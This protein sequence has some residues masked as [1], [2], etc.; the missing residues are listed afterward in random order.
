M[1][2]ALTMAGFQ[3]TLIGRIWVTPEGMKLFVGFQSAVIDPKQPVAI[4]EVLLI[5]NRNVVMLASST[6]YVTRYY[7][8]SGR[9]ATWRRSKQPCRLFE[10]LGVKFPHYPFGRHARM[11]VTTSNTRLRLSFTAIIYETR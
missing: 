7:T 6:H 1:S 5:K 9:T 4:G 11:Q 10:T 2:R 8:A 3:L